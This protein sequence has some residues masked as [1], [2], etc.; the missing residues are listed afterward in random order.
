MKKALLV[1]MI[2]LFVVMA[3]AGCGG[4]VEIKK[5]APDEG[6]TMFEVEGN[7]EAVLN[8]DILTV[9]GTTNLMDGTN[10]TISVLN[11]DGMVAEEVKFTKDGDQISHDFTVSNDWNDIVYGFITFDTQQADKQPDAVTEVYGKNFENLE[12]PAECVIWD[13][14]GVIAVFQSEEITIKS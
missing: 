2:L 10:G 1:T 9:S 3:F 7:C 5:P 11:S 14:K 8:G 12:G 4:T 6:A 13:L